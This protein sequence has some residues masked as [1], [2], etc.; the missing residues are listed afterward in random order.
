VLEH[1]SR[2]RELDLEGVE[3]AAHAFPVYDVL[4]PDEPRPGLTQAEALRNAPRT[5][6]GLFIVPKVVE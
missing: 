3:A 5:A 1:A 4:R 2:L 6:H